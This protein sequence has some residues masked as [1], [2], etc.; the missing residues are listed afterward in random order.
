MKKLKI[1]LLTLMLLT[2]LYFLL[3]TKSSLAEQ[4]G[5]ED[6]IIYTKPVKAVSFNHKAHSEDYGISCNIC[7]D[8]IFQMEA[9][10]VEKKDDFNHKSFSKGK[11]CGVCHDGKKGFA[12]DRQCTRCHIGVKGLNKISKR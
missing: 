12:M 7:H 6:L 8:K 11:Y 9:L 10:N 4:G 5:N 3:T 2:G 1:L